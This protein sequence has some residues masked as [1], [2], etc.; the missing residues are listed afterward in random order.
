[1]GLD[2]QATQPN[3]KMASPLCFFI[4]SYFVFFKKSKLRIGKCIYVENKFNKKKVK[5]E[6]KL[7]LKSPFQ[8]MLIIIKKRLKI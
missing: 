3:L 8:V 1:M 2:S 5:R 7:Y 6:V 4:S